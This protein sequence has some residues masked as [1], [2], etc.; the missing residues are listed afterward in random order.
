MSVETSPPGTDA[1]TDAAF[2]RTIDWAIGAVLGIVGVLVGLGGAMLYYGVDRPGVAEAVR[3][4]DFE[5]E[6]LT[7]AEAVDALVALSDWSGIGLVVAG[8]L[9]VA[10]GV[11]VVVVHGRART[12]GSG[13]PTWILGVAGAM[14][15]AILSFIPF[16][17]LLGGAAAAYVDPDMSRSGLGT[18]V[19][20]GV[21]ATAPVLLVAVFAGIGLFAGVPGAATVAVLTVLGVGLLGSAVYLV[22]LSALGG[23]VGAWARDG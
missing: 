12:E 16:S 4:A 17:P 18:G 14:I 20:A 2:G 3:E 9:T 7:E 21:F 15:G 19:L 13:T 10:V 8:A 6:T 1:T 22:G 11:A 5:S 23:Y